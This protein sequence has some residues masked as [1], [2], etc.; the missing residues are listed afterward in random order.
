MSGRGERVALVWYDYDPKWPE[1]TWKPM[2]Q[3]QVFIATTIR[4]EVFRQQTAKKKEYYLSDF[5][6][7]LEFQS[8]IF[9]LPARGATEEQWPRENAEWFGVSI[10]KDEYRRKYIDSGM[11]DKRL[12]LLRKGL[13][14][15]LERS[16]ELSFVFVMGKSHMWDRDREIKKRL[17]ENLFAGMRFDDLEDL[18]KNRIRFGKVNNLSL[19]LT[20]HANGAHGLTDD[21]VTAC[22]GPKLNRLSQGHER[23]S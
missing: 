10:K 2:N 21:E 20:T 14:E 5:C 18:G 15:P 1:S 6:K 12:S 8:N 3:R 23:S 13:I 19:F 9:P 11:L 16:N 7:E 22:I 17:E 4:A